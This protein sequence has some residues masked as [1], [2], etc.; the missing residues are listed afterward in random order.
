MSSNVDEVI[1]AISNLFIYEKILQAQKAQNAYKRT[2]TKKA[3][4]L[5]T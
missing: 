2:E 1:G 4:F 5:C 3:A